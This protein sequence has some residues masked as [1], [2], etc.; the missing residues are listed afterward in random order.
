MVLAVAVVLVM[1]FQPRLRQEEATL[2]LEKVKV[3]V[4]AGQFVH[5]LLR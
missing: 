2:S 1:E 4:E 3:L 5:H